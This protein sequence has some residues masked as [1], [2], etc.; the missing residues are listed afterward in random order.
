[1]RRSKDAQVVAAAV[2]DARRKLRNIRS[3]KDAGGKNDAGGKKNDGA[4][5]HLSWTPAVG[6]SVYVPSIQSHA[7]IEKINGSG[8]K[9]TLTLRKGMLTMSKIG[10]DAV[11][12]AR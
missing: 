6:D 1:V 12:R 9:R 4:R 2:A 7:V 8:D 5:D 11:E 3:E 10:L